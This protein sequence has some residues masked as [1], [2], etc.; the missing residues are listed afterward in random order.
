M[1]ILL[2]YL[3][4]PLIFLFLALNVYFRIRIIGKYKKLRSKN[5]GIDDKFLMK[6][7]EIRQRYAGLEEETLNELI[8][9]SGSLK[10]LIMIAFTGFIIILSIFLYIYINKG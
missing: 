5:I 4:I 1:S 7:D 6:E 9:F 3:V 2:S 10:R 8:D